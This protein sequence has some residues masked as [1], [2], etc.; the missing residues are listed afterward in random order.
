MRIEAE[1]GTETE[2][3][4]AN[5]MY[6]IHLH[7]EVRIGHMLRI[8][9]DMRY[10]AIIVMP[11]VMTALRTI[12]RLHP[13]LPRVNAAMNL[14]QPHLQV[15]VVIETNHRL[16]LV[17]MLSCQVMYLAPLHI[18]YK[19]PTMGD[20]THLPR[21]FLR[22]LEILCRTVATHRVE[23]RNS[24]EVT[25]IS[26]QL[27]CQQHPHKPR[28]QQRVQ[29]FIPAA[30]HRLPALALRPYK[31]M[32]LVRPVDHVHLDEPLKDRPDRRSR[33]EVPQLDHHPAIA[34]PGGTMETIFGPSTMS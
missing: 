29:V 1:N 16:A 24:L 11:G 21:L 5:E 8:K 9:I 26:N 19:I 15:H 23:N 2:I 7:D 20:S 33:R 31:L 32:S 28:P 34:T 27:E 25:L 18:Q 4:V 17:A 13:F 3:R 12:K 6:D 30:C 22:G 10:L 14:T